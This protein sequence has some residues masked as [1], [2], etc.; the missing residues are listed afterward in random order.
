MV[1]VTREKIDEELYSIR[2][3]TVNAGTFS[4]PVQCKWCTAK[5]PGKAFNH[6]KITRSILLV[7]SVVHHHVLLHVSHLSGHHV[8]RP[9]PHHL[10]H[11]LLPKRLIRP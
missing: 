2:L 11:R 5:S 4:I 7:L 6:S 3:A 10:L 8:A 9:C 1:L